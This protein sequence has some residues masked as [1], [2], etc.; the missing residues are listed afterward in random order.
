MPWPRLIPSGSTA[1]QAEGAYVPRS[2]ALSGR[3]VELGPPEPGKVEAP[4]LLPPTL[5][6][7]LDPT[8]ALWSSWKTAEFWKGPNGWQRARLCQPTPVPQGTAC[9]AS[10]AGIASQVGKVIEQ[11]LLFFLCFTAC[12]WC[13]VCSTV[14][15]NVGFAVS[16]QLM[17]LGIMCLWDIS[18]VFGAF[19]P[20]KVKQRSL[21]NSSISSGPGEWSILD[22]VS[23]LQRR[24]LGDN[25]C[26]LS[27]RDTDF[28]VYLKGRNEGRKRIILVDFLL[29]IQIFLVYVGI[30]YLLIHFRPFTF[31]L[32][33]FIWLWI[34]RVPLEL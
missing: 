29:Q 11:S 1:R 10:R 31:F 12:C 32:E 13:Y 27:L 4:W 7:L 34:L 24:M 23:C 16:A 26:G 21:W 17:G 8:A 18:V 19:L 33:P 2:A 20:W 28:C 5:R 14:S 22:T 9:S 15:S 3:R 6:S 25:F 30:L